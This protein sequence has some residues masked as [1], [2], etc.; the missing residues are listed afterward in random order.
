MTGRP[1]RDYLEGSLV[2]AWLR[3][4]QGQTAGFLR[5]WADRVASCLQWKEVR[6]GW[7]EAPLKSLGI[8]LISAVL[9][10]LLFA[11]FLRL[12]VGRAGLFCRGILLV[13]GIL[14]LRCPGDWES[15]REGSA[16]LR[17]LFPKK[18]P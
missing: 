11:L 9:A 2:I 8:L 1:R 14:S 16:V 3:R 6:A 13:F 18:G 17:F 4:A 15:V 12:P 7:K 10:N 5:K